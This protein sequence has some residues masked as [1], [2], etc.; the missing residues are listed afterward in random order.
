MSAR[1]H[2]GPRATVHLHMPEHIA[3]LVHGPW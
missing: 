3:G 1:N 2:P